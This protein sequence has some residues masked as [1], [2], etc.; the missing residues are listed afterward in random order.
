MIVICLEGCHGEE[1]LNYCL[2]L[3]CFLILLCVGSGKTE[4]CK[5]FQ[6]AGFNVLDE[7]FLDMPS[8]PFLHPQSLVSS[9]LFFICVSLF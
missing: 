4:L 2:Y 1:I 3:L 9:F 5:H 8:F 7:N 6:R